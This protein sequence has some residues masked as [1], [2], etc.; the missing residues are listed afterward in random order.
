MSRVFDSFPLSLR[1]SLRA[2]SLRARQETSFQVGDRVTWSIADTCGTCPS[3]A[4]YALPQKCAQLFKYG[5]A[6]MSAGQGFNGTYATHIVLRG[7]TYMCRLPDALP[8]RHAAP[9]NCAL[10]TVVGALS[11]ERLGA[12]APSGARS[13]EALVRR[14]PLSSVGFPGPADA[15]LL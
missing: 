1:L 14:A 4:Q 9:A 5:H 8:S 15:L 11:Q 6:A 2:G 13:M 10:A 12:V 3:C 7:G